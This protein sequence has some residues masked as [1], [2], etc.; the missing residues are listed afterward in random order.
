MT[1]E[2]DAAFWVVQ[3]DYRIPQGAC[4]TWAPW[5]TAEWMRK[6]REE[7]AAAYE[8]KVAM[9]AA[10]LEAEPVDIVW[11]RDPSRSTWVTR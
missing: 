11:T 3:M 7:R 6:R 2:A 9:S 10:L 1:K 5:A 8:A 4:V